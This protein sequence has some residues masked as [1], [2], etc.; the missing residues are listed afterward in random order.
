MIQEAKTSCHGKWY[1]PAGRVEKN[2]HLL[3]AVKREV[4]EETGLTMDPTTLIMVE[5][6]SGSWFRFIFTGEIIG[7]NLKTLNE[8]NGESLQANWVSN[9][10]ELTLR[11]NDIIPLIERCK[12][13]IRNNSILQHPHLLPMNKM[14]AKLILRLIITAKKKATNKVHILIVDKSQ[15]NLPVCEINPHRN[16]LSTL[17]GYMVDIF[18]ANVP[19]HKPHGLLSIEFSSGIGGGDG[20]CLTLLVSFKLPLEEVPIVGDFIW[21][22]LSGNVAESL[23][24]RLPR[25]MTVPLN[26]VR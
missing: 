19:Q 8:A 23:T 1:L 22:Q 14:H 10:S 3:D 5:C 12:N 7:G 20:L 26:V 11:S 18:G 6:A 13:Y 4:L 2:E 16:L 9:F 15:V 17:H 24:A 25:N 21:Y